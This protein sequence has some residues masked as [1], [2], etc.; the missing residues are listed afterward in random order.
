LVDDE[1]EVILDG[2]SL[3]IS[4]DK[5]GMAMLEGPSVE[6]FKGVWSN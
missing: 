4:W 6:V 3:N 5:K 1:V 2:G